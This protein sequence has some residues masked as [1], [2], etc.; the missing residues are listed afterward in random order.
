[1]R[2]TPSSRVSGPDVMVTGADSCCQHDDTGDRGKQGDPPGQQPTGRPGTSD[3][4]RD[5]TTGTYVRSI[6]KPWRT[7]EQQPEHAHRPIKV[8]GRRLGTRQASTD[9]R[10]P[11]P[12]F[13]FRSVPGTG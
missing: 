13:H 10:K 5:H 4:R 6:G 8:A 9:V 12:D 11:H 1:M 7:H 2:A 3:G